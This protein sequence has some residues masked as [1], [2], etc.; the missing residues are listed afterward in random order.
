MVMYD[1][2][3]GRQSCRNDD[4]NAEDERSDSTFA[5]AHN[6]INFRT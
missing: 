6:N 5:G 2:L 1:I 3:S 4:D